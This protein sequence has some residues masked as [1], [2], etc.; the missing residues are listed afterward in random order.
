MKREVFN[1]AIIFLFLALI[2]SIIVSMIINKDNANFDVAIFISSVSALTMT[3]LTIIYV[4][5]TFNQL[6]VMK[7][8]LKEMK[9]DR[10]LQTQPM[11]WITDI[12]L[13]IEKPK[14]FFYPFRKVTI[15]S[16]F[17][18]RLKLKNIGS[19]PGIGINISA[20]I[21]FPNEEEVKTF[22]CPSH[23]VDLLEV[24]QITFNDEKHLIFGFEPDTDCELFKVLRKGNTPYY[25]RIIITTVYRNILGGCFSTINNYILHQQN[26][27]QIDT[28]SDW[29]TKIVSLPITYQNEIE[30]INNSFNKLPKN[31][32]NQL[33]YKLKEKL[34]P[35]F[36][37]ENL[38]LS[39]TSIPGKFSV[40]AISID[41]YDK[42][43]KE[44]ENRNIFCS[45]VNKVNSK[46]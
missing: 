11:P 22:S 37:G 42:D 29:H 40:E 36:I 4:L 21:Y 32:W 38:I 12:D 17:H 8:Q 33:Y 44:S 13:M 14:M 3:A 26:M 45:I 15:N 16:R 43:I 7:K 34:S 35:S 23:I 5:T 19:S 27:K 39:A 41:E 31:E 24:D 46:K 1:I 25:P 9:N 10:E 30:Q 28:I 18:L 2:G 6:I 20:M